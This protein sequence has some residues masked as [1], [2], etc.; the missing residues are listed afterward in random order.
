MV[1]IF[2]ACGWDATKSEVQK[3][4]FGEN[5]VRIDWRCVPVIAAVRTANSNCSTRIHRMA[6]PAWSHI[7]Q[8][9]TCI[10]FV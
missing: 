4:E 2:G 6:R 3:S 1:M 5:R 7:K 9:N 10:L 8:T